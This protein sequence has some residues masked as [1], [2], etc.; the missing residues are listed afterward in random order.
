MDI[1]TFDPDG[2]LNNYAS[3]REMCEAHNVNYSTYKSR[4]RSG[5]VLKDCIAYEKIKGVHA[6]YL[7]DYPKVICSACGQ[8]ISVDDKFIIEGKKQYP[9]YCIACGKQIRGEYDKA[10]YDAEKDIDT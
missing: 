4:K 10:E 7:I 1:K 2:I 8:I 3:E 9:K 6:Y 5:M